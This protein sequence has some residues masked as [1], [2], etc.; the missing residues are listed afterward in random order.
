LRCA[1][2][3]IDAGWRPEFAEI[4]GLCGG[5]LFLPAKCSSA[6]NEIGDRMP[7][8]CV[9]EDLDGGAEGSKA[10]ASTGL[11]APQRV[12]MRPWLASQSQHRVY[13]PL[14]P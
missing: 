7:S 8:R 11:E 10:A 13:K 12:T 4:D 5:L 6:F 14:R 1:K 3:A 2:D 9:I